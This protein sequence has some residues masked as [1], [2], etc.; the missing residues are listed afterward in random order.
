M[1]QLIMGE[2]AAGGHERFSTIPLA[3]KLPKR[4]EK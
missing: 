1:L 3:Q 2:V 4:L